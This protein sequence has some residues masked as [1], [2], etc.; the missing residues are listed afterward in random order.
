MFYVPPVDD[1]RDFKELI[2]HLAAVG[3]GRPVDN[4]GHPQGQWT[5]ELLTQAIC[6]IDA[7]FKGIELRTV[8][9]WFQDN[10][11]G[12]SS[13]NIRWLARIFGCDDPDAAGAWRIQLT[14]A[15]GRLTA[16]RK[17]L[18]AS[19]SS[20]ANLRPDQFETAITLPGVEA[21]RDQIELGHRRGLNLARK[22]ESLFSS[23]SALNLPAAVWAGWVVL[24]LLSYI[25]G[26]HAVT[27]RPT[28]GLDKQVGFLW[29]PNWTV[30]QLI[31]LP[32][33][34]VLVSDLLAYWKHQRR[35][36][37]YSDGEDAWLRKVDSFAFSHW[38]TF[39]ICFV[40]VFLVQWSGIQMR[41][42]LSGDA[43]NI[44]MDWGLLTIMRPEVIS[45]PEATI[46]SILAF[47]Y[48][49]SICFLF[50]SGLVL[51]VTV[52]QDYA[53]VASVQPVRVD[54]AHRNLTRRV[55]CEIRS[56]IY[57]SSLL[58]IWIAT[59]VKLQAI[60]L[61]S[62]GRNIVEWVLNDAKLVL[63]VGDTVAGELDQRAVANLTSFLLLFTSCSV[64][65]FCAFKIKQAQR[66]TPEPGRG[67]QRTV[68]N[69]TPSWWM[70][71][72]LAAL[73]A[74][75]FLIGQFAG[76]SFLLLACVLI[77]VFSLYDPLPRRASPHNMETYKG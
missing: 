73:I 48:A 47:F 55:G 18:R 28:E 34:L 45:I 31:I 76:F 69:K 13:D 51:I 37:A 27:Y 75:F 70:L 42:L 16:K 36:L 57:K 24:G 5:P 53:E 15:N 54:A 52:A 39:F 74:N 4:I 10:D 19:V 46:L 11:K 72:V 59:C 8:Q 58:G 12:I 29:A 43:G 9:H 25:L 50:L 32:M 49:A 62:D 3:A 2:K 77:T 14:A 21:D 23:R 66:Q 44:M 40:V 67:D 1:G 26:V 60:Y 20:K 64:F 7:N 56:R 33:F 65:G 61:L 6:A 30:L 17:Q 68:S 63:G 71:I 35:L 22:I 41:A 38:A